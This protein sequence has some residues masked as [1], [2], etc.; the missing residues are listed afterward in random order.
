[1]YK[2]IHNSVLLLVI[3]CIELLCVYLHHTCCSQPDAILIQFM[4]P[5]LWLT[6]VHFAFVLHI[7]VSGDM[8]ML[9]S[10]YVG[11][12]MPFWCVMS[13]RLGDILPC[14]SSVSVPSVECLRISCS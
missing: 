11:L 14:Y 3:F 1:V 7:S 10:P 6:A 5:A 4:L 2:E 13:F 9:F 12:Q 8:C